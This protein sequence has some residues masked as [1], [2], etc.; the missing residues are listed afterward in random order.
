M[1]VSVTDRCNLRCAYCM[2]PEG[3]AL[4]RHED[5]L[6]FE[7][8]VEVARTAVSMGVTKLRLTGGEPLTRRDIVDLVRMLA[9]IE[10]VEDLSMSTNGVF[11][12]ENADALAK[13]GL[14]RVNV[15]LDSLDPKRYGEI[16]HGG[17]VSRV[18]D[19]ISA[20]KS[21]G[22]NPIKLN[23]VVNGA[24][25]EPDARAVAQ[26]AT[27]HDLEVRFISRMDFPSGTFSVVDGGSG[28][29]CARCSRLRLSSDGFIRP[30]LFSKLGFSVRELGP[31]QAIEQAVTHKPESG[32]PCEGNVMSRIGG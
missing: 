14:H 2:P 20:A 23:C 5:I 31:R 6:A 27:K 16:T 25:S 3:V 30:C 15:S 8:I 1:R 12:A 32:K 28:G 26:F 11:L 22:L 9:G 18:L 4:L 13:A 21:A 19:G 17:D 24:S 10:G 7:E 29:D